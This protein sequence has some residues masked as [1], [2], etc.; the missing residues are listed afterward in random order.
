MVDRCARW[1]DNGWLDEQI[2]LACST[3]DP[4]LCNLMITLGHYELSLALREVIGPDAGANFHTWAVWGSKKAGKT[5]RRED[6]S[7]PVGSVVRVVGRPVLGR[8][9]RKILGGNVTVLEDIGRVSARF[10]CA[11]HDR[12]ERD[13]E[14]LEA[15]LATMRPGPPS[16]EG[17]DLLARAFRHYWLARHEPDPDAK[18]EHMLLGNLQAILHEHVRLEPYI[19]GAMPRPLRRAVTVR[20]L[21]FHAG[22]V[23]L[24]VSED[25]PDVSPHGAPT[26]LRHITNPDLERFLTGPGGFDRTPDSHIGSRARDWGELRDR[27]NYIVDLFRSR[28]FDGRLFDSPYTEAQWAALLAGRVP[29]GPL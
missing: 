11:F 8:A 18:H 13:E 22:E 4:V 1:F 16:V 21:D 7:G 3:E 19:G 29:P 9:S 12:P 5:I 27:M 25:V 10:A 17:Q 26:S 15:F 23:R 2:S 14:R 28:H 20:L 6:L 24:R